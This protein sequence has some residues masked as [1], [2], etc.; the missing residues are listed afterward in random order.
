MLLVCGLGNVGKQYCN[1]RHN[2]G[3][4]FL[5]SLTKDWEISFKTCKN[6]HSEIGKVFLEGL[7]IL[8]VRPTTFMNNAGVSVL[9][10]MNYYK[11]DRSKLLVVHDEIDLPLGS[12][13]LKFGGGS[14]GHNGIKSVDSVLGNEYWRMRIGVGRPPLDVSVSEYVLGDFS[15]SE[16]IQI[17]DVMNDCRKHFENFIMQSKSDSK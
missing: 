17:G 10:V 8:F 13:R 1:T 5:E 3:F 2:A 16:L 12:I 15:K 9:N 14:A 4:L 11:I 7:E 6:L